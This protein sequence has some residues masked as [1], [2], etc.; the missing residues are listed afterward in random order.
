MKNIV[1]IVGLDHYGRGI[2]RLDDKT[3]FIDNTLIDE[4][5]EIDIIKNKKNY[6]EAIVKKYIK[7]SNDRIIPKCP[8]YEECGGCNIMHMEYTSQLK[9]KENKVKEVLK[10]FADID[11]SIVKSVIPT[12]ELNY[13]NKITLQVKEKIGLYKKTSYE[14][15]NIDECLICNNKINKIIKKLNKINLDGTNQVIIK[16]SEYKEDVMIILSLNKA[17]DEAKIIS[18]L[19]DSCTSIITKYNDKFRTLYGTEYIT[20]KIGKYL[21]R[22][23]ADSF[24]QVNNEGMYKLYEIVKKYIKLDKKNSILDLYCGTGTIGI[25]LSDN[26][27]SVTGIEINK[28]AI[29][30]AIKNK[31]IN[32]ITNVDFICDDVSKVIDKYKNIDAIIIDPPRNGL[33]NEIITNI[34]NTNPKKIVYVSCDPITLARDLKQFKELFTVE[35]II[36]VEMFA[37][38][39]HIECVAVLNRKVN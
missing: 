5:V 28:Y 1:K 18:E 21:F 24:F 20:E 11:K 27:N 9:F 3:V 2:A 13:R 6:S 34:L 37:N 15:I 30:D 4:E 32:N 36:P 10:K 38:T 26:C 14:L 33:N 17:I 35:V 7:T 22:I 19:K 8:Y 39:Y 16:M 29:N 31:K 25:Y 12:K 23:S